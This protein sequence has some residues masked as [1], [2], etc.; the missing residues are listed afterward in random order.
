MSKCR[1]KVEG[2]RL[3]ANSKPTAP[4]LFSRRVRWGRRA[5][6]KG[7]KTGM[8]DEGKRG[9]L[10]PFSVKTAITDASTRSAISRHCLQTVE[11]G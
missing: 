10:A 2:G 4:P 8:R 7:E 6:A 9:Y 5:T 1:L 3:K 11:S